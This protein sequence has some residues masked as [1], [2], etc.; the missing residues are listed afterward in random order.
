MLGAAWKRL[1]WAG[2]AP[3]AFALGYALAN[4]IGRFSGWRYDLPA[5]WVAYFYL[6]IGAA[7]I[8]GAIALLFGAARDR[9]VA[10]PVDEPAVQSN[11]TML[12]LI[13]AAFAVI[14]ALPWI[15]EGAVVA[16]LRGRKTAGARKP[17][18][19]IYGGKAVAHRSARRREVR[20]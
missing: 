7:E 17:P 19:C 16:A 11:W 18:R 13:C 3:L 15:A 9:V 10:A 12:G 4:G 20:G 2:L 5:D 8:L 6:G 1:R 14:G